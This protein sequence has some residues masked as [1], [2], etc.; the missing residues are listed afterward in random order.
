MFKINRKKN[1]EL[2]A[3]ITGHT[4]RLESINDGIFSEKLLGDGIAII[5]ESNLLCAP[6]DGEILVVM[7]DSGHA[8]GMKLNCG[9]EILLHIGIDTVNMK[10]EGFEVFVKVGDKVKKG[11]PLIKFK[12]EL[13]KQK[14]YNDITIMVITELNGKKV[15]IE[16]NQDVRVKTDVI[17]KII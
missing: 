7:E 5:P 14:N 6:Q 2:Y 12:R 16:Y 11:M 1:N 4:T 9:I 13:I 17:A 3:F 8:L 10:H 15:D